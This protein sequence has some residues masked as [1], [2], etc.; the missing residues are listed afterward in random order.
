MVAVFRLSSESQP[1]PALTSH[2]WDKL[3]H[4]AEYAGLAG[5]FARAFIAERFQLFPSIL[6][7]VALTSTYGATDEYHQLFVPMRSSDIHDWFADTIGAAIGAA[8]YAALR[9]YDAT[10]SWAVTNQR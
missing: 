3:L 2:V 9:R 1:L 4:L 8:A 5:L 7:A 10:A 6:L